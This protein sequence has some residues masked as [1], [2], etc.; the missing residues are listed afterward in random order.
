M[1]SPP[2]SQA[3]TLMVQGCAEER[4]IWLSGCWVSRSPFCIL[5]F[6]RLLVDD[7]L[8]FTDM[9]EISRFFGIIIAMYYTS[10]IRL[11]FMPVMVMHRRK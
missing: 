8:N 6:S 10:I 7:V 4:F 9:P 2:T 5:I 3:C 1:A 11:I